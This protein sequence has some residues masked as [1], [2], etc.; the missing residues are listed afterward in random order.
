MNEHLHRYLIRLMYFLCTKGSVISG[1]SQQPNAFQEKKH[2]SRNAQSPEQTSEGFFLLPESL[3]WIISPYAKLLYVKDRA[4]PHDSLY[5]PKTGNQEHKYSFRL[6]Y[7]ICTDKELI[8]HNTQSVASFQQRSEAEK[9]IKNRSYYY[10]YEDQNKPIPQRKAEGF[11]LV[12]EK[13]YWILAPYARLF[14]IKDRMV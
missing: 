14:Y 12:P 9:M 7:F 2:C 13:L 5:N 10:A 3:Q 4:I 6:L 8:G 1:E 11:F